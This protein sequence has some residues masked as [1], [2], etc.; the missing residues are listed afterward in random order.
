MEQ[1]K[2][3]CKLHSHKYGI[4]IHHPQMVYLTEIKQYNTKKLLTYTVFEDAWQHNSTTGTLSF[5]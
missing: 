1:I 5:N 2:P 4:T 3:C